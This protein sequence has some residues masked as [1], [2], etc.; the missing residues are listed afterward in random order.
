MLEISINGESHRVPEETTISGLIVQ[1]G[2]TPGSVAVELNRQIVPRAQHP[3]TI[4]HAGDVLELVHF[5][6]GG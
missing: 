4:L 2:L 1:L 5:V 3:S 6:G